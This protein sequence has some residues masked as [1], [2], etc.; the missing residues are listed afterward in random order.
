MTT[1]NC[2][3]PQAIKALEVLIAKAPEMASSCADVVRAEMSSSVLGGKLDT[4]FSERW[5][6]RK[7]KLLEDDDV[8]A[9]IEASGGHADTP[10]NFLGITG[11]N[12]YSRIEEGRGIVFVK[13]V[14]TWVNFKYPDKNYPY[15]GH[16]ILWALSAMVGGDEEFWIRTKLHGEWM[17][18]IVRP[19]Y[20][21]ILESVLSGSGMRQ[22]D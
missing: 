15:A 11:N 21:Q 16:R 17:P 13:K 4:N 1:W 19:H 7:A 20:T 3:L 12:I 2:T 10:G 22:K 18:L 8:A 5:G 9:H 14:P 6:K